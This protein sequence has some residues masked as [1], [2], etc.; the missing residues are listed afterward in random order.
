ANGKLRTPPGAGPRQAAPWQLQPFPALTSSLSSSMKA[1][2]S[3]LYQL[4]S[5]PGAAAAAMVQHAAAQAAFDPVPFFRLT[6]T[7][8]V[9]LFYSIRMW[10][11]QSLRTYS[12]ALE[13]YSYGGVDTHLYDGVPTEVEQ[14]TTPGELEQPQP[15]PPPP[16]SNPGHADSSRGSGAGAG[17]DRSKAAT[18]T[19]ASPHSPG[20][21][22][23]RRVSTFSSDG[24]GVDGTND[25]PSPTDSSH[26]SSNRGHSCA[27]L[28]RVTLGVVDGEVQFS[29]PLDTL[30]QRLVDS[31]LL[32]IEAV[33]TLPGLE[34]SLRQIYREA[35]PG[36]AKGA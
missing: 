14:P 2:G 9:E 32:A 23:A 25:Q 30:C 27:P 5:T 36:A 11:L 6:S 19:S 20:S 34:I 26:S 28:F 16:Y 1:S 10:M 13:L 8:N 17:S 24:G 4:T 3:R 31:V 7:L 18:P 22:F 33:N 35:Y 15:P 29:P 12:A 21:V